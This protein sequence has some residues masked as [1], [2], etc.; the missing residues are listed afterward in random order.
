MLKIAICDDNPVELQ[1]T[2]EYIQSYASGKNITL[3][4]DSYSN[5]YDLIEMQKSNPYP[6]LLLDIVMPKLSGIE[7]ARKI[8]SFDTKSLILYLT[9]SDEYTK[10]A[11][12]VEAIGYM[13]KPL[14]MNN[15][16]NTLDRCLRF[17]GTHENKT[18]LVPTK[19]GAITVNLDTLMYVEHIKHVL[20]FHLDNGSVI[21][22]INSSISL[23][24]LSNELDNYA[25][26]IQPHRAYLINMDFITTMTKTDFVLRNNHLIPIPIRRYSQLR[27]Q[28]FDYVLA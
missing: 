26:F 9:T 4:I 2:K 15:I 18:I 12:S 8:R 6:L 27:K 22:S 10:E 20:F 28:Y 23:T 5:G 11:Y 3:H 13:L 17:L 24:E 25:N 14:S 7:L 21:S 19:D 16:S 1:K